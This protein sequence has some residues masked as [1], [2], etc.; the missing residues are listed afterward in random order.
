[1]PTVALPFWFTVFELYI[2]SRAEFF[3]QTAA[4]TLFAHRKS[5]INIYIGVIKVLGG[6][7]VLFNNEALL[8]F[9]KEFERQIF[10]K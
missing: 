6:K 2:P 8:K 7:G 9:G 3:A 1:M 10:L 4:R 5:R